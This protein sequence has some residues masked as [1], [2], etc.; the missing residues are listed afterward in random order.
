[1]S[2]V[3]FFVIF[4]LLS[5]FLPPDDCGAGRDGQPGS[6]HILQHLLGKLSG[7]KRWSVQKMLKQCVLTA[8]F[9]FFFNLTDTQAHQVQ[10]LRRMQ[11]LHC[12]VWPPLSVGG[13]LCR[14]VKS[15]TLPKSKRG[16]YYILFS[17]ATVVWTEPNFKGRP[18]DK[19]SEWWKFRIKHYLYDTKIPLN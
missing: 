14:Y 4:A 16:C 15:I 7:K 8:P 1:M 2:L 12:Q 18:P 3:F 10:T 11:P 9:F 13:E 19:C 17:T 6:E 5:G